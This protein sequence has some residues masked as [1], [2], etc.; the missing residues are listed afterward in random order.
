MSPSYCGFRCRKGKRR[1]QTGGKAVRNNLS[2][3]P[4]PLPALRGTQDSHFGVVFK[5]LYCANTVASELRT[6]TQNNSVLT[7]TFPGLGAL[8]LGWGHLACC[9]SVVLGYRLL[10]SL[11]LPGAQG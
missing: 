1:I 10:P 4:T 8:C 2:G 11:P 5:L 3:F 6:H 7:P 9:T